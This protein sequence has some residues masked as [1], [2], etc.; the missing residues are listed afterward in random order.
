MLNAVVDC[1]KFI[2]F[3]MLVELNKKKGYLGSCPETGDDQKNG[4]FIGKLW[5]FGKENIEIFFG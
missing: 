1:V 5:I 3:H 4:V 2:D